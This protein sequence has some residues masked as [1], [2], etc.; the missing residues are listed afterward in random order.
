MGFRQ[1]WQA[2][3]NPFRTQPVP[4]AAHKAPPPF[5]EEFLHFLYSRAEWEALTAREPWLSQP[6]SLQLIIGRAQ[7]Q[8][9]RSAMLGQIPPEGI[10]LR[11]TAYREEFLAAGFNPRQR[12]VMDR[13]LDFAFGHEVYEGRL[14]LHEA[15]TPFALLFRG[16]YARALCSE[17]AASAADHARLFPIPAIDIMASGLPEG[18]FDAI[19]TQEVLEHVPD[20]DA[21][22][23]DM[24]RILKPGGVAL[25]TVPLEPSFDRSRRRAVIENG[26]IR[27]IEPPEY[28]G[29]PTD[30]AGGSLAF[31]DI[32]WDLLPRA[33]AAGFSDARMVAI[34]SVPRG[35]CGTNMTPIL[36]FEAVR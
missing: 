27:H 15:L 33:R 12:A 21:A 35:I 20:L 9:I 23:V 4:P 5:P 19:I 6:E 14:H 16:R 29:N 1:N 36:L 11:G 22:L 13:V 7:R 24:A 28:H 32:G 8:G 3:W 31:H 2:R 17:Y 25:G 34:H 30:P 18:Q 10:A 26:A